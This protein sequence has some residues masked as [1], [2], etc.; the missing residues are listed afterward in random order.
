MTTILIS[1]PLTL[2]VIC[3][4]E[5]VYFGIKKCIVKSSF[6]KNET[7]INVVFVA[8]LAVLAEVVLLPFNIVSSNTIRETFPFEAYLQ[9]IPFKSISFYISHMTNYHIMIQFFGNV[10]LLAPLAIYM[11]INRSISVLKNLILA[12]CLSFFIELSQSLLNLISQYPNNVSDID[13]LI[14]NVI[15]YMCALLLVPW[16]KTIFKLKNKFH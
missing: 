14:L 9:V 10:L 13:D 15:G 16:F 8:Y 11:N 4:F 5:L 12:L 6:N 1:I 2:I 3:I 7:L